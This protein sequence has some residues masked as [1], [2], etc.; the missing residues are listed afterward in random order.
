MQTVNGGGS[1][2]KNNGVEMKRMVEA[3][4]NDDGCWDALAKASSH[5]IHSTSE[6]KSREFET[7]HWLRLGWLVSTWLAA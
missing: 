3:C 6:S 1:E 2:E 7:T 5:N 4:N